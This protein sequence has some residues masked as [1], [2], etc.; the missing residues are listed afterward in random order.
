MP[1][2]SDLAEGLTDPTARATANEIVL[3]NLQDGVKS[4]LTTA[5]Y[6]VGKEAAA[7]LENIGVL[8]NPFST[9]LH[10]H[11]ADKTLENYA[12][13]Q[14][15]HHMKV[16]PG[17]YSFIQLKPAKLQHFNRGP[18]N[19]D[20][21]VNYVHEPKDMV[22]F[23]ESAVI[24][25]IK[26]AHPVAFIHDTLH[27]M[28]AAQVATIFNSNPSL[29]T[30][31]ATCV[32]P[33]E[34][35]WRHPSAFPDLYS[36]D[37]LDAEHFCYSPGGHRGGGYVHH[38]NSLRWLS[39]ARIRTRKLSLVI[40]KLETNAAHHL[41]MI[42][43][44]DFAPPKFFNYIPS[45]LVELPD[46]FYPG[47][48]NVRTPYSKTLVNRMMMYCYSVKAVSMRD[49]WAK[50]RQVIPTSEIHKYEINDLV[51]LTNFFLVLVAL[52]NVS[53]YDTLLQHGLF[54]RVWIKIR[55]R[56][57]QAMEPLVGRSQY[58][59]LLR[60]T[61]WKPF[62]YSL[63]TETKYAWHHR[64]KFPTAP[65]EKIPGFID[66]WRAPV[67]PHTR[68]G[69]LKLSDTL[70]LPDDDLLEALTRLDNPEPEP[71]APPVQEPETADLP[72]PSPPAPNTTHAPPEPGCCAKHTI[73][74]EAFAS[75]CAGGQLWTGAAG[76]LCHLCC[77]EEE[78]EPPSPPTPPP[79]PITR[80]TEILNSL[81][82][83]DLKPQSGPWGPIEPLA[84]NPS[85]REAVG[86][87]GSSPLAHQIVTFM[88]G[89]GRY[90]HQHR[91]DNLRAGAF[92]SDGKNQRIGQLIPR[93]KP[94][95]LLS[96]AARCESSERESFLIHVSGAGG[97]G[98]S[99]GL[100]KILRDSTYTATQCTVVVPT[101]ELRND[102]CGKVQAL[103]SARVKTYEKAM[104]QESSPVTIFD[105]FGKLPPGYIDAYMA[106]HPGVELYILTGDDRQSVY[107][108]SNLQATCSQLTPEVD[109]FKP[110]CEYYVN[111]THRQPRRFANPLSV[112]SGNRHSGSVDTAAKIPD[113]ATVLVPSSAKSLQLSEMG[114]R[115][116]TYAG[117]QGLTVK[118]L[119][120][121]LDKDTPLCSDRVMYT[122]LSR[123]SE[124]VTFVNT[125]SEDPGFQ[126]KLN[127]TPYLK[128]FLSGVAEDE[129]AGEEEKPK[130]ADPVEPTVK[131]HIAVEAE[132]QLLEP[133]IEDCEDKD[134]REL[135]SEAH[136]K[137]DLAQSDNP[138]IQLF[139]HQQAKDDALMEKTMEK[140]I[141]TATTRENLKSKLDTRGLGDLLFEAY[142]DFTHV[143]A[144]RQAFDPDLWARSRARAERTYLSKTKS[145]IANGAP[146]QDPDFDD[147]FIALFN[148]SQWV[149]KIAKVGHAFKAGQTISSFKQEI[150]LQTTTMALYLRTMRDQHMPDNI[151]IMCEKTPGELNDFVKRKWNFEG[152][153]YESDYE[154]YDQSQDAVFLNFELRK[155]RHFGVPEEIL[156]LYSNIKCNAKTF[157][158]VLAIM[159]LS[160]EGPTLDFNTEGNIAYDALRF[161]LDNNV[162]ALYCGDDLAR[163]RVCQE[164]TAWKL[165]EP[166][167]TLKAKPV[168]TPNPGFCGWRLTPYGVVKDPVQ[169]YQSMRLGLEL[170]KLSEILPSYS[171]DFAHAYALGDKVHEIFDE[172][173]MAFHQATVRVMHR[174]GVHPKV[175]GDHLPVYHVRSDKLLNRVKEKKT[176]VQE[177]THIAMRDDYTNHNGHIMTAQGDKGSAS[178]SGGAL[179]YLRNL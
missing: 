93:Q 58:A 37:Y 3:K 9:S 99:F 103:A 161:K 115:A 147:N 79:E 51:R 34:A 30:L 21:M 130:E 172:R 110:Y 43:R 77:G 126:E 124:S 167:F 48:G 12:L 132:T 55:A 109:A 67:T 38:I 64:D 148:K 163:D 134:T 20:Q 129:H 114:R 92:A 73:F 32:L 156:E 54:R 140:R 24:E 26:L 71:A 98:K 82:F 11:A 86:F 65:V 95:W 22:R 52:N 108:V 15:A 116:M 136:G 25:H 137:T 94:D 107:N 39:T 155:A 142:A 14:T 27:H 154:A 176:T 150:V 68:N 127:C 113:D 152:D 101:V 78:E 7:V 19:H 75:S 80:E 131:T 31:F 144:T 158:G 106:M 178:Y 61:R 84:F 85:P 122:A 35:L 16:F 62:H 5:P 76:G 117:C 49:I 2:L 40:E 102:W 175:A 72:P 171:L 97:S 29:Q 8:T 164:R 87:D 90:V 153:S 33:V 118:H 138:I 56:I 139:P 135:F 165:I 91:I 42:T 1:L 112:F 6:K 151:F 59:E 120:I 89:M 104:I 166:F 162:T 23:E 169:L 4:T 74:D 50:L 46:V 177:S 157:A 170:G 145:Q 57:G 88:Q 159:R 111:A 133:L 179:S 63:T 143:P 125:Y 53:D 41:F 146:R 123:A 173:D 70:G 160:G 96:Y 128:T 69:L 66:E 141:L 28:S 100:Q 149:K 47:D 13:R 60:F 83:T 45:D 168:V 121:C 119:V 10:S 105:D 17:P 36:I 81:G 44:R 18:N 174:L